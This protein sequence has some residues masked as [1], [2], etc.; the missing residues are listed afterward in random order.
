MEKKIIVFDMDETIGSFIFASVYYNILLDIKN[1][2]QKKKKEIFFKILDDNPDIFRKNI[3]KIFSIFKKYKKEKNID[4]VLYTNNSGNREYTLNIVNY[5]HNKLKFKL[6]DKIITK[7]GTNKVKREGLYKTYNDFI[8]LYNKNVKV[9]FFD[10]YNH[11]GMNH[12]NVTYVLLKNYN[13]SINYSN[14]IKFFKKTNNK[15][16][17]LTQSELKKYILFLKEFSN[18]R[19]IKKKL[20]NYNETT[21]IYNSIYKFLNVKNKIVKK[22]KKKKSVFPKFEDIDKNKDGYITKKEFDGVFPSYE[23]WKTFKNIFPSFKIVG[24]NG[25]TISKRKFEK[26]FPS[27]KIID[28]N[29]NGRISKKEYND[30]LKKHTDVMNKYKKTKKKVVNKQKKKTKKKKK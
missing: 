21:L 12:K 23:R 20:K 27:F 11:V 14:Y 29:N 10:D 26:I 9:I 13:Y 15:F 6:F 2:S 18:Q 16:K 5:I 28:V 8:K 4:V 24:L 19:T 3:F 22:I 1:L 7:F 17:Y 25:N 30:Y